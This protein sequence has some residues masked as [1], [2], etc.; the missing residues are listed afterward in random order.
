M[1]RPFIEGLA[2]AAACTAMSGAGASVAT[3]IDVS[4]FRIELA[5]LVPGVTAA[6]GFASA[7]G[8]TSESDSSSGDP[9][10]DQHSSFSSG[11]AFGRVATAAPVDPLAGSA[12][13]ISGNVFGA[14][15]FIG[16]SAYASSLAPQTSAQSTIGLVN[17]V[18]AASFT[19]APWT[20]MTISAHVHATATSTG[21]SASELADSGLLMAI[22]DD[23]GAGPQWAYV[24]FNAF[25]FGGW[26]AIDDTETAVVSLTYENASDAAILGLFS[27]YVASYASSGQS[28]GAVPEPAGAAMLMAGLLAVGAAA[29]RRR[30]MF[31]IAPMKKAG[32]SR[33]GVVA[34]PARRATRLKFSLPTCR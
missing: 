33:P 4:D 34:S 6:A 19:L 27:G 24:N 17:G 31:R 9:S 22:G 28:A 1:R 2:A 18:S 26:G 5:T 20:V 21:A 8:S 16:T 15:A 10:T 12:A 11:L 3:R 29:R 23:Q 32:K 30:S 7:I 25:A 14:G 13:A